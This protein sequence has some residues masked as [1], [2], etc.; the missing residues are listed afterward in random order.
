MYDDGNPKLAGPRTTETIRKDAYLMRERL[1][2]K[3]TSYYPII[4]VLELVIPQI[5]P[6]FNFEVVHNN[7]LTGRQA[8]Y[9]PHINT[10]RVKDSIYDAACG[11]HWESRF[12][13]AHELGHYIYH[14]EQNVWFATLE[15]GERVPVE[16]DPERQAD[17]FGQETLAPIHLLAGKDVRTV[18]KECGVPSRVAHRQLRALGAVQKRQAQKRY[19]RKSGQACKLDR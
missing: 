4:H 8:E 12:T 16:Y 10:I 14:D 15:Q 3:D 2:F 6:S 7:E 5:D 17:V 9:I 18:C 11:G 13:L 19:N 1:G